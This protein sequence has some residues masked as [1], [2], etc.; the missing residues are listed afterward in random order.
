[1]WRRYLIEKMDYMEDIKYYPDRFDVKNAYDLLMTLIQFAN[2]YGLT[3]TRVR[4]R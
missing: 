1:M 4:T 3:G 2:E